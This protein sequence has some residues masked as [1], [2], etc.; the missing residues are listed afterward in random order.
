MHLPDLSHIRGR[1]IDITEMH[2]SYP[3]LGMRQTYLH[4]VYAAIVMLRR[5]SIHVEILNQV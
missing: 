4:S 1:R 2:M 5:T 3:F